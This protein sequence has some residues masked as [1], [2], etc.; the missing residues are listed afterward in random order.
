MSSDCR[1]VQSDIQQRIVALSARIFSHQS[2][3]SQYTQEKERL[4]TILAELNAS[5][6]G[7]GDDSGCEG[8]GD[9]GGDTS[10]NTLIYATGTVVNQD[11]PWQ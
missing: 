1:N 2:L 11:G 4:E 8:G 6:T 10:S 9:G 3:I 7:G 5:D